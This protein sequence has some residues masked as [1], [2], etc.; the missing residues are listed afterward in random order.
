MQTSGL[1]IGFI[2]LL[3]IFEQ[4]KEDQRQKGHGIT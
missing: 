3:V 2:S 4:E 1:I